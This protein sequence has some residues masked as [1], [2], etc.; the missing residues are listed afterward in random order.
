MNQPGPAIANDSLLDII[1]AIERFGIPVQMSDFQGDGQSL[2]AALLAVLQQ[3]DARNV[4]NALDITTN[5]QI[6]ATEGEEA[7]AAEIEEDQIQAMA[8]AEAEA[9]VAS[10]E[11][12]AVELDERI[13]E[14]QELDEVENRSCNNAIW[15]CLA[16]ELY[17]NLDD[18]QCGCYHKY[19]EDEAMKQRKKC[20]P[21]LQLAS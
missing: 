17:Y 8:V 5:D 6:Q 13:Q 10:E 1:R 9:Y 18:D 19:G 7:L 16:S 15:E 4:L 21:D 3:P 20:L 11:A 14:Q 2:V 12:L